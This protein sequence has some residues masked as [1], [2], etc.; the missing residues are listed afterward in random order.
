MS[1]IKARVGPQNV[2]RVLSNNTGI[3][4]SVKLIDL[5][6]VNIDLK[7]Q[8]GMILVWDLPSQTFIMTSVI[9]SSSTTIE[10]IVYFEN[11]TNSTSPT[12]GALVVSGGVGIGKTLNVFGDIIS[13]KDII[14]F[15][16][17]IVGKDLT[18]LSNFNVFGISTF[19][20]DLDINAAVDILNE[21]NVSGQTTLNNLSVSGLSTFSGITTT[22]N[23]LYVGS[24][25][26]VKDNLKVDGAS[27]FIGTAIFRG[28]TIGIGDSVTD[29]IDIGGEIV[30]NL[31]PGLD[32]T[33]D[34][35][36]SSQR[37]RNGNFAGFV[38]TTDLYVSGTS[39]FN[40]TVEIDGDLSIVGFISVTDGLYYEF[41]DYN[42]PNGIGYFDNT[43][44]LVSS[45]STENAIDTSNYILTTEEVYGSPVWTSTIDGGFY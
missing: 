1:V 35:G 40:G 20:S 41:G 9:D 13:E 10:G 14:S 18:V 33:Y 12:N 39:E 8:D 17:L 7:T 16:D 45:A 42:P 24:N 21:L 15:Q 37:W 22:G 3:P 4:R 29:D 44:K 38:T 36:S 5:S 23:D 26:F 30:S 6:D 32:N 25:L 11:D 28:G 34:I 19:S 43:G 27:E 31:I 2:V